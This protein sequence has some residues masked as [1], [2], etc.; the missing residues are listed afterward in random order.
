M[1]VSN[2]LIN[3]DHG[4]LSASYDDITDKLDMSDVQ[5]GVL[6]SF[7]FGGLSLGA[8]T[9]SALYSK[10]M[11][12]KKVLIISHVGIII[13]LLGFTISNS[14]TTSIFIRAATGFFQI[15]IISYQPV[16]FD[17]YC[18]EQLKSMALTINMISS[19]FGIVVGYL[20]TYA[21]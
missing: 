7:V 20:I 16:W 13:S 12:I 10:G 17:T 4:A 19:P 6:S 21:I 14:F 9:C 8:F 3:I 5:Y 11:Y 1:I 18:A 15:F 2:I